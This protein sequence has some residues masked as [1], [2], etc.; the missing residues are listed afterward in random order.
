MID[1]EFPAPDDAIRLPAFLLP[2]LLIGLS[3]PASSPTH[4]SSIVLRP[5]AQKK[6]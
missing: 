5:G 1:Y 3:K 6:R 2:V 4:H